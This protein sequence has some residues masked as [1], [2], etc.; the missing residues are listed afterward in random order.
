M[1]F[2]YHP[3]TRKECK[4][5][6]R[7]IDKHEKPLVTTM[8]GRASNADN[9]PIHNWY[10]FVL[11]YSPRFP[12][13]IMERE[14]VTTNS[15]V[16]DP[17]MGSGTTNIC[18]KSR[19][20]ESLG[21]DANDFFHF[22]A[23]TKLNWSID[24]QSAK[25][26]AA[27]ILKQYETALKKYNWPAVDQKNQLSL[28]AGKG[29]DYQEAA[30]KL[31]PSA[32]PERYISD[33]PLVRLMLLKKI[34]KS[35][36][37]PNE[38]IKRLFVMAFTTITLPASNVYYGPGFGVRKPKL[39]VDVYK[40]FKAKLKR[41]IDDLSVQSSGKVEVDSKTYLGDARLMSE[42]FGTDTVDLMITSPP[43]PGDHEY[44]KH[45]KI[46]LICMDFATDIQ[47]F[48]V[49]KKRML[50][51]STTNI[52][53]EDHDGD[54][55][56]DMQSIRAVTDEIDRRLKEDNATSGFEKLYTKLVW[57]Y[58]GG[59]YRVFQEAKKSLK[60]GGKFV[61]LVSDSHAFKMVHIET[62]E[63]LAEVAVKAGLVKPHIELWQ[64]KA[65][66][67]HKYNL[68]EEVLTVEKPR[69]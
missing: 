3:P 31:R 61:L 4:V 56:R 27:A 26:V 51:G 1:A 49:I 18:A 65:S 13:Y 54:L 62:A 15:V 6:E 44:T 60:P 35:F 45:S 58:F 42:C 68:F 63:I 57:E 22:A 17:F 37:Y 59:M 12:D 11:G 19:G 69:A 48:R 29:A 55:V 24:I 10:N 2:T 39:D 5:C 53:K 52:Y 38:S 23:E 32:L 43:Y 33:A 16:A 50:R 14:K 67:S 21:L 41:M 28:I 40:L 20:V 64:H 36:H 25:S 8:D 46:E 30:V 47:E 7:I 66:T 9:F 34:I